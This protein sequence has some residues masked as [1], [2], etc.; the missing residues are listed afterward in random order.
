MSL[1]FTQITDKIDRICGTNST[2]YTNASKATDVNLALADI[3]TIALRANGWNADD[4]NHTKYPIIT[5]DLVANQQDYAFT[6]DEQSNLILAIHKV[7]V[8]DG[9]GYFNEIQAVDQQ[10]EDVSTFYDG[11]GSSGV[12]TRYDK[13]ANGVF[14]DLRPSYNAT[15][16]LKLFI[17]REPSFFV[18]GDTTKKAGVD[19]LCHDYLYL[20]PAYEYCR[21]KGLNS[22]E[23]LYRDL[24]DSIKRIEE[25]Y[26]TKDRDFPTKIQVNIESNK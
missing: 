1:T 25:R 13:T 3:F 9:D 26:A 22:V 6:S 4:W 17:D 23:R 7:L 19:G 11:Q 20:K 5:T 18:E 21:D 14:L 15:D 2:S 16:G 10:T 12:P 24:Q 8:D